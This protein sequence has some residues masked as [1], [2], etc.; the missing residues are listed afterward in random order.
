M[1]PD[2][3]TLTPI[4]QKKVEKEARRALEEAGVE[5]VLPTPVSEILGVAKVTEVKEDVLNEDADFLEKIRREFKNSGELLRKALSKVV[6]LFDARDGLI[7][8]DRKLPAIKQVFVRLHEAGHGFLPWQRPMYSVVESS[9][10]SLEPSVADAFDREANVFAAEILFQG[11]MF[12]NQAS[13]M[14]QSIWTPIK[15]SKNYG[16]SIYSSIRQYV[17]KHQSACAVLVLE[18]PTFAQGHGFV[19]KSRRAVPSPQFTEK[20][21]K[22]KW[23]EEYTPDDQ[24][25]QIVPLGKARSSGVRELVLTDDN[26]DEHEFLAEAFTNTYQVFILLHHRRDLTAKKTFL[27]A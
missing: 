10:E 4:R 17:S 12:S 5:G 19:A 20:F 15:L 27:V 9:K 13:E 3:S 16:A 1:K 21:G 2:D 26:G 6:G 14:E 22:H 25:G 18:M 11:D 24:I 7:F 23:L 8:I